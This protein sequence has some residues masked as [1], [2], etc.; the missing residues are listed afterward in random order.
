LPRR[1]R[2]E[3]ELIRKIDTLSTKLPQVNAALRLKTLYAERLEILLHH[4]ATAS[5]SCSLNSYPHVNKT[6]DSKPNANTSPTSS[7]TASVERWCP[8]CQNRIGTS[9]SV[10]TFWMSV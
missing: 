9:V 1:T 8:A 5:I 4:A 10:I 2:A 3:A 6:N 7:K